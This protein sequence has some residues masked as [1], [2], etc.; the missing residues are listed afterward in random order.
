M[1]EALRF[2]ELLSRVVDEHPADRIGFADLIAVIGDR[3]LGALLLLF[4]LPNMLPL[5]PGMSL[6]TAIPLILIAAQMTAG[7]HQPWLPKWIMRQSIATAKVRKGLPRL[8]MLLRPV[9]RLVKPRLEIVT[10]HGGTQLIGIMA[11]L[12]SL[13]AW[14]PVVGLH[15]IPAFVIAAFGIALINRD[16]VLALLAAVA[17][18]MGSIVLSGLILAGGQMLVHFAASHLR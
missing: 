2:S 1:T 12:L 5:L 14:L 7:K 13:I 3:S 9:E 16:G 4:A 15:Y 8:L 6:V 11:L 17:G 18:A 10:G